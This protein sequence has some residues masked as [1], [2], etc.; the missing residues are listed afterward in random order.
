MLIFILK[1]LSKQ[2]FRNASVAYLG[3]LMVLLSCEKDF[4]QV[5]GTLFTAE[6]LQSKA[7]KVSVN[8]FQ[9]GITSVASNNLPL[10]QLGQINHPVFG[11]SEAQIVS[12]LNI[13]IE[14]YFGNFRQA[15]EDNPNENNISQIPEKEQVKAV[16][17]EIPFFT[18]QR[19]TDNDGVVDA[20][21]ADPNDPDSNSDSDELTDLQETQANLNPLDPDSDGDGILD[22]D[23]ED[24][25]SY[26]SENNTYKIDSLYGNRQA[27]FNL[28]VA[29]LTY[30]LNNLDPNKNFEK[31]QLYYSNQDFFSEG[32]YGA[33]LHDGPVELNFEE[34]RFNYKEDDPETED[35]DET[36]KVETRLTP[37][38]RVP[39]DKAFFQQYILDKEDDIA[40]AN[41]ANFNQ[42]FRG[43][44]I[45]ADSFSDDLYMLLDIANGV[46]KIE[47]TFEE[48]DSNGTLDTTDDD[49][50]VTSEKTFEMSFSGIQVNTLKNSAFDAAISQQM[51]LSEQGQQAEK[52]Y[53]KSGQWHGRLRLFGTSQGTVDTDLLD[54]LRNQNQLLN[55]ARL[56]FYVDSPQFL[57]KELIPPRLYLYDLT[58]GTPLLDQSID[59]SENEEATNASKIRFGGLLEY[60]ETNRPYRYVFTITEHVSNILRQDS[61]N[62]DLGLVVS[63]DVTNLS[64]RKAK[65]QNENSLQYP[66]AAVL[67][68]L[69][70]VLIG[71][72]DNQEAEEKKVQLELLFT[73][74]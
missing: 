60:D 34:L 53:V 14:P 22:H 43:I 18:N 11:L 1:K 5:S 69:G 41:N 3:F 33:M 10:G 62:V 65:C 21:D 29:Q 44:I 4:H 38:L 8:T 55:E 40:L 73:A 2:M 68:P 13:G 36:T 42:Y 37:R 66:T 67:N 46:I 9:E 54:S 7:L 56:N 6:A 48:K 59:D 70:V 71:S 23:D 28:K 51:A 72:G 50:F 47:Y 15:I 12:Q 64:F 19:D 26:D 24:S 16:Y 31:A 25:S 35:V 52:L 32:F 27:T 20:F 49:T 39:L 63:A 30:Y 45:K 58:N 57:N 74:F 61:T 17:L